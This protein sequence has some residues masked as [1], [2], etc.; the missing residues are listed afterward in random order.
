MAL[1]DFAD[2]SSTGSKSISTRKKLKNVKLPEEFWV[3]WIMA[4]P[5]FASNA[6]AFADDTAAK[7][8]VQKLDDMIENGATGHAM[9]DSKKEELKNE[10]DKILE[11]Q[12]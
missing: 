10:R 2:D 3:N 9:S 4:Y 5:S 11:D 7:A 1:D 12:L 6:A 8:I